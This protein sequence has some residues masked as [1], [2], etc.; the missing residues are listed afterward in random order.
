MPLTYASLE[1][2]NLLQKVHFY[3]LESVFKDL[4]NAVAEMGELKTIDKSKV[5]AQ[6]PRHTQKIGVKQDFIS[7]CWFFLSALKDFVDYFL[8]IMILTKKLGNKAF[9]WGGD[10][11]LSAPAPIFF[12]L[13]SIYEKSTIF[14]PVIL[15][16]WSCLHYHSTNRPFVSAVFVTRIDLFTQTSVSCVLINK[17]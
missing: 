16:S 7:K 6:N 15:F 17:S 1:N 12:S 13:F 2:Q 10:Y 9:C 11:L 14:C 8:S 5:K 4:L 3:S